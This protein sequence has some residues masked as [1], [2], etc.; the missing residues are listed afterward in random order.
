M[1]YIEGKRLPADMSY[2]DVYC[3]SD[4]HRGHPMFNKDAWNILLDRI[5]KDPH[6]RMIFA[7]DGVEAA[8]KSSKYGETY[9]SIR[10]KEERRLLQT[11]LEKVRD[12][13]DLI[14]PGNHDTRAEKDSDENAMELVAEHLDLMDKYDPISAVVD[15]SFG[16][17]DGSK[18][19]PTSFDFYVSHGS[20]GG[21]KPGG[22]INRMQEWAWVVDGVDGYV[23]GHVHDL[24][25]R[26]EYRYA[27]DAHN[28]CMVKRAIAYVIAGSMLDYGGY[29]EVGLYAPNA[30]SMPILRLYE[31]KR[32]DKTKHMQVILPTT[33]RAQGA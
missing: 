14:I 27:P 17:R 1:K 21:R 28:K 7:G 18:D 9:A 16:T 33:I 13:I 12:K 30:V 4:V 29:A 3:V 19:R 8:L 26:V 11:E 15:I 5:A 6:A 2:V 10:P 20:G 22:K 23:G 32:S 31:K 25:S 24:M